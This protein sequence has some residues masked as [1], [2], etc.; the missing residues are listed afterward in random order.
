VRFDRICTENGI[1]HLLTAPFSPTTT[2]K[3]ERLHKTMR[4]EFFRPHERRHAT[5]AELQTALDGWVVHYNTE[6]PH[7][8]VGMCPPVDRFRLAQK[9]LPAAVADDPDSASAAEQTRPPG[10]SRWVDQ[11]GQVSLAGFRYRVGPVFVEQPVEVV[12]TG[13]LVEILHAGVLVATHV[14]RR[15]PDQHR[16]ERQR[17]PSSGSAQAYPHERRCNQD[18]W[19]R[20]GSSSRSTR[21]GCGRPCAATGRAGGS[22]TM[23]AGRRTCRWRPGRAHSGPATSAWLPAVSARPPTSAASGPPH[24]TAHRVPVLG[25]DIAPFAVALAAAGRSAPRA[26]EVRLR[27]RPGVLAD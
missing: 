18:S 26:G 4:A 14:Q 20:A 7:Q 3:V 27:L 8:A 6:R 21:P 9:V 16:V 1:R 12:V 15:R 10:V 19:A 5:L 23:T 11:A 17:Q 13:G 24:H 22:G 25:V 2:G